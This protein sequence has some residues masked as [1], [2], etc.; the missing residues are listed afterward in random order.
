MNIRHITLLLFTATV[1]SLHAQSASE[2]DFLRQN[3]R[4]AI[5]RATK[6]LTE[7]YVAELKKLL[8][9][10]TKA[11][12]LDQ[13]LEV[14]KELEGI[15]APE[16]QAMAVAPDASDKPK[17]R[18]STSERKDIESWILNKTWRVAYP[19]GGGETLYFAKDGKAGRMTGDIVDAFMPAFKWTIEDDGTIKVGY[20][21]PKLIRL[22]SPQGG[23]AVVVR[24]N[25]RL[26]CT[27]TL[28]ADVPELIKV[29]K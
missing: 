9:R 13:A 19:S 22:T 24:K 12:K 18:I 1:G 16:P 17:K 10:H 15:S 27:I 28:T 23:T 4:K 8:D 26:D 7:T 29:V 25:D 5:D 2:L 14:R 11:G 21:Y 6:P 3:Y 20:G